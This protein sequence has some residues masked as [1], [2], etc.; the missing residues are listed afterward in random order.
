[1]RRRI[2]SLLLILGISILFSCHERDLDDCSKCNFEI[3]HRHSKYKNLSDSLFYKVFEKSDNKKPE[4]KLI[5]VDNRLIEYVFYN[6]SLNTPRFLLT[7]DTINCNYRT[8]EGKAVYVTS[9]YFRKEIVNP[10]DSFTVFI[11]CAL[12]PHTYADINIF[13]SKNRSNGFK[14]INSYH[15]SKLN[16]FCF[17]GYAEKKQF[18]YKLVYTLYDFC[19]KQT[20]ENDSILFSIN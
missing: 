16:T 5:V 8:I 2:N 1:M 9:Q 12:P 15:F 11:H 3:D 17:Y 7:Y 13:K 10:I 14:H 4:E 19:R 18:N 20:L 6:K